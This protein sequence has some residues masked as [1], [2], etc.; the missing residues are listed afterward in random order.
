MTAKEIVDKAKSFIGTQ[1]SPTN[2]NNVIFNTHFYGR[3]VKGDYP[4]CCVFV[5]DVF[6]LCGASSLFYGGKKT[7]YCPAL[8]AWARSEGLTID[9]TRG[10]AGDIIFFDFNANAK[11]D[12]VGIV[13]KRNADGSYLTIE[14]NTSITS[15][16]NGGE[17]MRRTRK[18]S[19]VLAVV[20]PK[21]R[22][23]PTK[24]E[25]YEMKTFKNTSGKTLNIYADS[26]LKDKVGTLFAGS[27]CACIG[28]I[29][30]RAILRY[31]VTSTGAYKV[32]FTDYVKGVQK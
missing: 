2:S 26:T 7:D 18:L 4:W 31:M 28:E 19:T 1:E 27:S 24:T 10:E 5:W 15:D 12:H 20:R 8:L 17:V 13:E 3:K 6:R 30:N 25:D 21:Y 9:K 14:G 22:A 16:D 11:P 32:G 23:T 29:A